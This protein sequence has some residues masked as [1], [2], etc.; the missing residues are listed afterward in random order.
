V[1]CWGD[2]R[3]GRLGALPSLRLSPVPVAGVR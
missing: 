3:G 1:L 2:E